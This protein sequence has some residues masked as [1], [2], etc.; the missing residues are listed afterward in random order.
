VVRRGVMAT[1]YRRDGFD[2]VADQGFYMEKRVVLAVLLMTAVIFLTNIL[3]PPVP[4]EEV[5]DDPQ[6]TA[7]A[8]AAVVPRVF[9]EP[10]LVPAE[11][12][13]VDTVVIAS[14]L[15]RYVISSRGGAVLRAELLHYPSYTSPG[16]NVQLVPAEVETLLAHRLVVGPD[17]VDLRSVPFAVQGTSAALAAGDAPHEIVLV[18]GDPEG[19]AV[20]MVYTFHADSYLFNVRGRVSG[21]GGLQ[22]MLLTD[23]GTALEPHEDPA[24]RSEAQLAVVGRSSD[25]GV[26]NRRL[27]KV[28]GVEQIPGPLI[29]AGLKDKYFLTALI[30]PPT[31]PPLA[32]VA[33]EELPAGSYTIP[34]R[35]ELETRP[36]PRARTVAALPLSPHDG[37]F[38]FDAYLG[39]QEYDRLAA[40]GHGLQE[41]NP[42]GY[43]FLRPIIRPIAAA[44]LWVLNQLHNTLGIG[45]G[46]VLVLFGVIMRIV[47][48]PLNAKAMRS[49]MKNMAVQPLMQE[50]REKYKDD[51]QQMQKEMMTLYREHG[52]NPFAGCLPLLIPM[53]VLITLFFVFQD[54]IVFRGESFFWL[55]DLSLADPYY[56][57]PVF[58]VVSMFALQWVSFK[59]SGM[60]QNP[61]MKMMMYM[62]PLVMG[63]IF[64][65]LPAGLN[66]YYSTTNV[67]TIPQ[68]LIISKERRRA[69][70]EMKRQQEAAKPQ[71][72]PGAKGRRKKK[73]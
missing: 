2:F 39:P 36:L 14:P 24:H 43:R 29:W 35:G 27:E 13:A 1:D 22:G 58:L 57:L 19:L 12:A 63:F 41:V 56:I 34:R 37:T 20:E 16:D 60:E 45:Y 18:Y 10:V 53:P 4:P 21:L 51:P 23:L 69:Q 28:R 8:P 72:A 30:A 59:T 26:E 7:G 6:P 70:E 64:F 11:P 71:P 31:N 46:W 61:Q 62:M 42:Y 44:I 73:A 40:I 67:A 47:L 17:T 50:I 54:S 32:G 3:F 25:R 15:Y 5:A 68:Q 33:A 52:F 55:P 48:W 65:M 38:A 49:Q 66:L 9:R